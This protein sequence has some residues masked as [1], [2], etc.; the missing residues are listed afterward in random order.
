MVV[1]LIVLTKRK[2][3]RKK[4]VVGVDIDGVLRNIDTT[5]MTIFKR[6]HPGSVKSD[7]ISGWDF[8]N[9]DLPHSVKMDILFKQ[10]PE[11]IFADSLP[12][13]G[14]IEEFLELK[15]WVEDNGGKV[16]C[17]THQKP[18]IIY[19]SL[20]WLGKH[21]FNFE[22]IHVTRNKH[23]A[24]IDY[25]IDDSPGNYKMWSKS[26]KD[27]D[28]FLLMNRDYNQDIRCTNR[29]HKLTD[30]INIIRTSRA[31]KKELKKLIGESL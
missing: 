1:V 31:R 3:M 5:L 19:H 10:C 7:I 17:V 25:L 18:D 24:P 14:V 6:E 16:A 23:N 20:S 8:P 22:E 28:D 4:F 29:V 13:D 12:Y 21:K 9:V 2:I 27:N 11:E 15:K 26:K 30:A